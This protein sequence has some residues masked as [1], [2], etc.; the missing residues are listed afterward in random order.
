MGPQIVKSRAL[1]WWVQNRGR[2]WI[3]TDS[4]IAVLLNKSGQHPIDVGKK[5]KNYRVPLRDVGTEQV[6]SWLNVSPKSRSK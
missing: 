4:F 2:R 6:G 1:L 3:R 5:I